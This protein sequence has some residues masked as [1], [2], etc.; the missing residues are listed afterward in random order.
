MNAADRIDAH[1]AEASGWRGRMLARLRKWIAEAEPELVEAW[2][3][4]TPVWTR[5]G[6][7]VASGAFRDHVKVNFFEGAPARRRKGGA[8]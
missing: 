1:I 4:G 2:K 8:T 6:N 3:W 7:V 5:G